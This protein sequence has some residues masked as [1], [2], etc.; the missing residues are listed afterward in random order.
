[1]N[2]RAERFYPLVTGLTIGLLFLVLYWNSV[3]P[4]SVKDLLT[5]ALTIGSI[6]IGFLATAKSILFSMEQKKVIRILKD[7][8][9]FRVLV[10]YL[11][12]AVHWSFF[13]AVLSGI[14]LLID[15]DSPAAWHP[16]IFS[17]WVAI[18]VTACLSYYRVVSMFSA[19]LLYED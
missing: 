2:E 17:L 14:G 3:L 1:M 7:V 4:K 6:S 19:V 5:A 15:F 16:R 13:W 18:T 12:S 9:K 10:K 8:G 11:M